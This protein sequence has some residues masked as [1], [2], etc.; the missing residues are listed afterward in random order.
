MKPA[1]FAYRR[2]HTVAEAVAILAEYGPD[3]KVL[4]GGQSLVPVLN[5]RLARPAVLVDINRIAELDY[6]VQ[7]DGLL[8]MGA[9][10]RQRALESPELRAICPLLAEAAAHIGHPATRNRGTVCGSIAHADPAA[11]LP[12]VL[13]ALDGR[14]VVTGTGGDRVLTPGEF[15]LSVFTTALEPGELVREVQF[16]LPRAGS[17]QA[18]CEFSRRHG[19]FAIVSAACV[20]HLDPE[21]RVADARIALGGVAEVPVRATAAEAVLLGQPPGE[22]VLREAVAAAVAELD[23]PED[24]HASASFRKDLARVYLHRALTAAVARAKGGEVCG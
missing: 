4:A 21:G 16:P 6:V 3:A 5:M 14:V 18:F 11:E 10:V 8:R 12:V 23:P 7:E 22:G 9:L 20:I 2:P 13:T 15:F 19:D 17:G 24:L 1:P